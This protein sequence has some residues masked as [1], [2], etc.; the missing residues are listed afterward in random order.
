MMNQKNRANAHG[1]G[2][3]WLRRV[4]AFVCTFA[5]LFSSCGPVLSGDTALA[6]YSEDYR[7]TS[8][9]IYP[10]TPL[11]SLL[12]SATPEADPEATP[13]PDDYWDWQGGAL[14]A[15]GDGWTATLTYRT[16]AKIPDG[17]VLTLTELK[18][19]DLYNA[20]KSA[21]ALL[22]NDADEV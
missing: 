21:A 1:S 10:T 18:G 19:A 7:V 17:A 20:M 2:L 9:P 3:A 5:M 15:S 6:Q 16:E 4:T 12:P 11:P 13:I 14:T 22:K 8:D